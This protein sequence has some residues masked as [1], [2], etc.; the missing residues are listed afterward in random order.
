MRFLMSSRSNKFSE[1]F[2]SLL[3]SMFLDRNR[4]LKINI[5]SKL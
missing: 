2:T 5:E 4:I 1:S 3:L